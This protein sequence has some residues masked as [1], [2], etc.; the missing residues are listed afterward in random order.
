MGVASGQR[1]SGQLPL[2]NEGEYVALARVQVE[3]VSLVRL[4]KRA[5]DYAAQ[6]LESNDLIC[7]DYQRE[8]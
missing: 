1:T 8:D 6:H 3:V 2:M 5:I 4:Q 7:F